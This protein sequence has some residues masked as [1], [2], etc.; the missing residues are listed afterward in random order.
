MFILKYEKF[1]RI[2]ISFVLVY[3]FSFASLGAESEWKDIGLDAKIRLISSNEVKAE[4]SVMVGIEMKMSQEINTYWR[5][6]GEVGI[7][8]QLDISNSSGIISKQVYWP[9]PLREEKLGYLDFVHYGDAVF[10][11]KLE[12]EQGAAEKGAVV[13]ADI[14]WGICA[15]ICIPVR[16]SL[17]L[18]LDF[19]KVDRAQR[20][21]LNL[22]MALVPNIWE[23]QESP[24]KEVL[25]DIKNA[26]LDVEIDKLIIDSSSIIIDYNDPLILFSLPQYSPNS[27]I[28][29][30]DLL[31]KSMIGELKGKQARLTFQTSD[32][33]FEIFLEPSLKNE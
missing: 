19:K 17:E 11:I 29:S 16:Q 9:Y 12:L 8:M 31:D 25:L 26:R 20:S 2:I 1:M 21:K 28:I 27:S 3:L 15:N 22:A 4:N 14:F 13:R 30:F 10:P 7:P 33:A 18:E 23:K 5:I 32:G 24:I 6:P